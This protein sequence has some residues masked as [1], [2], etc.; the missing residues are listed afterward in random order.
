MA[1]SLRLK[2][3]VSRLAP[4][5]ARSFRFRPTVDVLESRNLLNAGALDTAFGTQGTVLTDFNGNRDFG[6][7]VV[8]QADGKIVAAGSSIAAGGTISSFAL[9]R[10]NT[11]GTLDGD[12]G[13]GGRVTT[14]L[15]NA[16]GAAL[17]QD[18]KIV[19]VGTTGSDFA[20]ARYNADGSLDAAFGTGGVVTTDF[21]GSF[22]DSAR[23]VV[24]QS[25]GKIVVVG[26]TSPIIIGTNLAM[27]RY[28]SDGTL[29][30]AFGTGGKVN[31]G[32][33]SGNGVALQSDG[34]IVVVGGTSAGR[35]QSGSRFVIL[36]FDG[37]GNPDGAFGADGR[38]TVDFG[39]PFSSAGDVV[40]EPD[41]QIVAAGTVGSDFALARL[42]ANG[43]VDE[44]FGIHGKVL[45]DFGGS[46]DGAVGVAVQADG[47]IVAA[48]SRIAS[49]A[50]NF[51]FAVA[52]YFPDGGLDA[53]FGA[54]GR[55]LTTLA[56]SSDA[57]GVAIQQNGNIIAVGAAG[58]LSGPTGASDF[59]LA[60][61]VAA[62][63]APTGSPNERFVAQL[64]LDLLHRP[65]EAA[66]LAY[67]VGFLQA[68]TATRAQV[69]QGILGSP[70]YRTLV[71]QELYG[72]LLDRPADPSGLASW[73]SFLGQGHSVEE[74][75]VLLMAS[76]EFYNSRAG[77]SAEGFVQALFHEVLL[78]TAEPAAVQGITQAL[79]NGV[80]RSA[81]ATAVLRSLEATQNKVQGLY[82]QFLHRYGSAAEA[83]GWVNALQ[84]Q[85]PLER[86]LIGFASSDEY[87][88]RLS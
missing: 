57:R 70:E 59:A 11:D 54:G 62:T 47:K 5:P 41:D 10:Y 12:F 64:Y 88:A 45:T 30:S 18:G 7:A 60:S 83:A 58:D 33:T 63:D 53:N 17:Q 27:A 73:T 37:G 24:I 56:A 43:S 26:S 38:V 44:S 13:S 55:V 14:L 87:F 50:P 52:R 35:I 48:G 61:Y 39:T 32:S 3:F 15:G 69:V 25:D 8:R 80:P 29:D 68:G 28:N 51:S 21:N 16:F 79:A 82:H 65:A 76:E 81:I 72:R 49:S 75:A 2:S 1:T 6:A 9:A 20:L 4:A 67:H 34:K 42:N 78:R 74:V 85:L 31:I 71:I 23:D 19:V 22:Q 36:R 40:I 86:V 46:T 77:A 66:G 84:A